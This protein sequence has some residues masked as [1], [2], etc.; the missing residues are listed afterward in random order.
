MFQDEYLRDPEVRKTSG[1]SKS[2]IWRKEK[3]GTFPKRRK[4]S[5][6]SVGWLRSEINAWLTSREPATAKQTP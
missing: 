3:E 2:T 5:A 4:L 6:N 1:L